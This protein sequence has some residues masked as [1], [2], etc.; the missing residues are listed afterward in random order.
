MYIVQVQV[1]YE[2]S[3]R[4]IKTKIAEILVPAYFHR[5]TTVLRAR[6]YSNSMECEK[7]Q[8]FGGFA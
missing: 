4:F 1:H 6:L 8:S 3:R 2:L 5:K 7:Y